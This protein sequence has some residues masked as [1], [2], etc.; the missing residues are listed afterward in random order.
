MFKNESKVLRDKLYVT[1]EKNLLLRDELLQEK[2]RIHVVKKDI[3]M[4]KNKSS[5]VEDKVHEIKREVQATK[6]KLIHSKNKLNVIKK[7]TNVFIDESEKSKKARIKF[8]KYSERINML[9][10]KSN[11]PLKKI[12]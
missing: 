10:A 6:M 4:H 2:N 5:S 3:C 9:R 8:K 7:N 12:K 11:K 1:T